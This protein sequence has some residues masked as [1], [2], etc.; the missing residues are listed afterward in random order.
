V[1]IRLCRSASFLAKARCCAARSV[2]HWPS[3]GMSCPAARVTSS[4]CSWL[5]VRACRGLGKKG[6]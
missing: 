1:G 5:A 4:R 6:T 2:I 3:W